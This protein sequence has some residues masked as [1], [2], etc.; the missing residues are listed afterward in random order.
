MRKPCSASRQRGVYALEWAFIFPVFFALLYGIV[1][2]GLTFLVR[3]SMQHAVEEGARAA[4]QYPV[5]VSSPNWTHREAATRAAVQHWLNWLPPAIQPAQNSAQLKFTVCRPIG[6]GC[7]P[8]TPFASNQTC[9]S[10]EPCMVLVSY[11][12]PNYPDHAIAPAIPGLGLIL[13][14]KLQAQARILVDGRLL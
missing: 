2:Y 11:T 13:P 4:L 1:C 9:D 3:S 14:T 10:A 12:I 6:P 7:S 5:G 8:D